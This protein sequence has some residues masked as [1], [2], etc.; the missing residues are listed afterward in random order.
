MESAE[1]DGTVGQITRYIFDFC[2]SNDPLHIF[3]GEPP[4]PYVTTK[5]EL[6]QSGQAMGIMRENPDF[7]D[8]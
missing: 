1:S 7:T 2:K 5:D 4:C 8:L 6:I 3:V